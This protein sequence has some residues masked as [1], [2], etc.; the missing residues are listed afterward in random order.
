MIGFRSV[1]AVQALTLAILALPGCDRSERSDVEELKGPRLTAEPLFR[2]G[3]IDDPAQSFTR[4]ESVVLGP[5]G[6]IIV[7]DPQANLVRVYAEDGRP[8]RTIGAPGTGPG[9]FQSLSRVDMRGDTLLAFD[10]TPVVSAFTMDGVFKRIVW[11][12]EEQWMFSRESPD[13]IRFMYMPMAPAAL[14]GDSAAIITPNYGYARGPM[15]CT[16]GSID[17]A[18]PVPHLLTRWDGTIA[19]TLFWSERVGRTLSLESGGANHR[20]PV[21]FRQEMFVSALPD[22]RGMLIAEESAASGEKGPRIRLTAIGPQRDTVWQRE[23]PVTRVPLTGEHVV[24][25]AVR[26]AP[27]LVPACSAGDA[28]AATPPTPEEVAAAYRASAGALTHLPALTGLTVG[29]DGS[30]WLRR[31]ELSPDSVVWDLLDPQGE[32]AGFVQL[33][34][35]QRVL[36]ARDDAFVTTE[37]DE[38]D[39]PYLVRY[40]LEGR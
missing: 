29:Q 8:L 15:D 28:S 1:V 3:S 25:A 7:A 34:I 6:E 30:I 37:V 17:F 32:R 33:P 18:A 16:S 5:T 27:V 40:R 13:G 26:T 23:L 14:I 39:V 21:P 22:G 35:G 24:A 36:A 31:E 11:S 4:V 20:W 19:D 9:H 12:P 38:L 10:N 2:L